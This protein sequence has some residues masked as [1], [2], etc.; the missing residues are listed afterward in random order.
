MSYWLITTEHLEDRLLFRDTEDYVVGMNYV[1]VQA[2]K[3]GVFVLAF[4]LMSNHVHFVLQCSRGQAETFIN[5]F[6][7]A[8][9]RYLWSKY[10]SHEH[11]R[12]IKV[13][14]K[15]L[16]GEEALEWAIAYV[17]MNCVVANICLAPSDYR[18]GTGRTFFKPEDGIGH[19]DRTLVTLSKRERFRV[20]HC[21]ANVPM[22]W[23]VNDMGYVCPESYVRKELVEKV[24]RSPRRMLFFLNNSS[25]AKLR[26]EIGE[27]NIPAFR[28]QVILAAVPDLCMSLFKKRGP[29]DLNESELTELLRQLRY[30]FSA[31]ANQLARVTGISYEQAA[32]Y[33]DRA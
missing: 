24:Y 1:P 25:K 30:R 10:G 23:V 11:L 32:K 14:Y 21:R 6:K 19:G 29:G 9:S 16:E 22:T 26:L 5:G 28:D 8:Y 3:T 31:G 18:W 33:L 2:F 15:P 12:R 7:T 27:Q 4:I 20:L 13:D 17:Q